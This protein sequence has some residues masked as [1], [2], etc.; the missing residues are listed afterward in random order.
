MTLGA[1]EVRMLTRGIEQEIRLSRPP[2]PGEAD[3]AQRRTF[4]GT[5]ASFAE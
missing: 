2:N 5:I 1:S 3:F 4:P